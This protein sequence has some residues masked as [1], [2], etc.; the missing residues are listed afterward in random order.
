VWIC[1]GSE[2]L[3][4]QARR[5]REIF[6]DV[7]IVDQ[8]V[9]DTR[10]GWVERYHERGI[11]SYDRFIAV[12]RKIQHHFVHDLHMDAERIDLIYS[13]VETARFVRPQPSPEERSRIRLAFNLLEADERF[14]FIGR[15]TEQKRPI[16]FLEI[17]RGAQEEGIT[18]SFVMVG[19]GEQ[20]D[21]VARFIA[22]HGLKNV[23]RIPFVD[24]LQDLYPL[25]SGLII[26]SA[27][28]GLP[29]AMLESLCCG[30]PVLSTDTGDIRHFLE[31]YGSGLVVPDVGNAT[32]LYGTW[33][34]WRR[35]LR[36]YQQAAQQ[37]AA[38]VRESFAAAAA[39]RLYHDSWQKA[40]LSRSRLV[41]QSRAT[42]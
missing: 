9:Y 35:R 10:V 20:A 22:I 26:T 25:L 1:N 3:C 27:F 38:E 18:S 16:D 12:T 29:I 5:I 11:Q 36:Q 37:R 42:A 39:A 33:K 30:V 14:A 19:D 32:L 31:Y 41:T 17:A 8:E 23:T 24:R 28:E 21:S 6:H 15:L 40:I 2:W 7:P 34:Q 4:N 13:A